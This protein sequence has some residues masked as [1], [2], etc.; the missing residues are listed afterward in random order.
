M[1]RWIRFSALFSSRWRTGGC[2]RITRLV[3]RSSW[4][5][6]MTPCWPPGTNPPV[7]SEPMGEQVQVHRLF[8]SLSPSDSIESS[9]RPPASSADD[10]ARRADAIGTCQRSNLLNATVCLDLDFSTSGFS[11]GRNH[12][13]RL[14]NCINLGV[15]K[16][17][18]P[19]KLRMF[20]LV[21]TAWKHY[22]STSPI[23]HNEGAGYW[24]DISV[25]HSKVNVQKINSYFTWTQYE[26]K[27]WKLTLVII[28]SLWIV[29]Q[30]GLL[31]GNIEKKFS[32]RKKF[33]F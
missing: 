5:R 17:T 13:S 16:L 31:N 33:L 23:Q 8:S 28:N 26:K 7:I 15:F 24:R 14:R 32:I 2:P 3:L 4:P 21:L 19:N 22:L 25:R 1:R 11:I 9:T 30:K 10:G 12:R 20:E 6:L 29:C 27:R 18:A